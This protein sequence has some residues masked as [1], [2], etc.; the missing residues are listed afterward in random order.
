[1]NIWCVLGS[2]WALEND[3]IFIYLINVAWANNFT[4]VI[5]RDT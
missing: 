5:I 2:H 3:V 1:M 4:C